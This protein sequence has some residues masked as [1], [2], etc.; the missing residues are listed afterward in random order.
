MMSALLVALAATAVFA[1]IDGATATSAQ[2]KARAVATTLAH[3]DQERLRAMD[4]RKLA[5]YNPGPAKKVVN[6]VEYPITSSAAW[7]SFRGGP[8]WSFRL[9]RV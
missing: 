5:S 7:A 6:R 8:G 3:E 9:P 1:G 4:P 2:S